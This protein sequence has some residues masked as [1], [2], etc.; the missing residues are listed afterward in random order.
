MSKDSIMRIYIGESDTH[1]GDLLYKKLVQFFKKEKFAG[2]TAIKGSAGFGKSS[3]LHSS[4]ILR[5]SQDLPVIIEVVD[6]TIKLKKA[7][8]KLKEMV[9]EGLITIEP[10]TVVFYQGRN[11]NPKK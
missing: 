10:V 1:N 3:I 5:L 11:K 7:L 4:S 6:K 9:K 2:A 8:P